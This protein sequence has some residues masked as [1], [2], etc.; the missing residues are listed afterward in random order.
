[1][2]LRYPGFL[3]YR[4]SFGNA[5]GLMQ[6][7]AKLM[8]LFTPGHEFEEAQNKFAAFRLFAYVD[9]ELRIPSDRLEPLDA[10]TRRAL[11]LSDFKSIWA[12]EGVAHYYTSAAEL[13]GPLAGLLADTNLPEKTMVPMHAGMGTALAGAL[14]GRLPANPSKADLRKAIST[15]FDICRANAR[16]GWY[17]NAIEPM[18]LAVRS[19]YPNLLAPVS[20]VI[21]EMDPAAQNLFWHGVGRSLYFVPM[22]FMTFAAAHERALRTAMAEAPTPEARNNAIAGLVWAVAL[23]NLR[24]PAVLKNLLKSSERIGMRDAVVN[25]IVS[26]LMVWKHMVPQDAELL[27]PYSRPGDRL[28]DSYVVKPAA[29]AFAGAYPELLREGRVASVFAYRDRAY[30]E[31]R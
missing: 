5:I 15:F 7:S 6:Q 17:E 19:M 4:T 18:G 31:N 8:S 24:Q 25:G 10:L 12:L 9:Q 14:L 23:V 30:G 16:A 27:A 21:G 11:A 28:W 20:A 3:D 2:A 26:A 13:N 29:A 22:N 1:M